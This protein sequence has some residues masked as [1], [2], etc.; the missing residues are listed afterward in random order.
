MEQEFAIVCFQKYFFY[1]NFLVMPLLN[2]H[3]PVLKCAWIE[4][5]DFVVAGEYPKVL[6]LVLEQLVDFVRRQRRSLPFLALECNKSIAVESLQTVVGRKP[7]EAPGILHN[8]VH[9]V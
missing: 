2:G 8:V 6:R 3:F 7:D 4:K 9:H 1:V 5:A